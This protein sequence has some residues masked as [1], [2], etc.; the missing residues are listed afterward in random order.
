MW[1]GINMHL[2]THNHPFPLEMPC[3]RFKFLVMNFYFQVWSF[4][5][6]SPTKEPQSQ[7]KTTEEPTTLFRWKCSCHRAIPPLVLDLP[8]AN[9]INAPAMHFS[10][11]EQTKPTGGELKGAGVVEKTIH[12]WPASTSANSSSCHLAHRARLEACNAPAL[13]RW[14]RKMLWIKFSMGK[15]GLW[16]LSR[17]Q[18]GRSSVSLGKLPFPMFSVLTALKTRG[19]RNVWNFSWFKKRTTFAFCLEF[20]SASVQKNCWAQV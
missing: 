13:T 12:F 9:V 2:L 19:W 6:Y 18:T 4:I 10:K 20:N 16:R 3:H 15:M 7:K 5:F 17:G 8:F 1:R 11:L 14:S